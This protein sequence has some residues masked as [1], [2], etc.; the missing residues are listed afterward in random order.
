MSDLDGLEADGS[1]H[2]ELAGGRG[3]RVLEDLSVPVLDNVGLASLCPHAVTVLVPVVVHGRHAKRH[4][5]HL[6]GLHPSQA[7]HQGWKQ[8]P[9]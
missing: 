6:S 9:G 2:P 8:A 3:A 7:H 5:V 4:L 1:L